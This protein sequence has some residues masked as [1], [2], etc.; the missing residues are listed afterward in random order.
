MPSSQD[1][2][3]NSDLGDIDDFGKD[4]IDINSQNSTYRHPKKK[5]ER[6]VMG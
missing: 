2:G 3:S 5:P 1:L 4:N 6:G